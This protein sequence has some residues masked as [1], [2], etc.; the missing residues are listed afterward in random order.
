MIEAERDPVHRAAAEWFAR[1][2]G[3]ELSL[4]E[5]LAWQA[6]MN[7]NPQNAAAFARIEAV[8]TAL[9]MLPRPERP[10]PSAHIP[11]AWVASFLVATVACGWLAFKLE[12]LPGAP[13]ANVLQTAPGENRTVRLEDGSSVILGG[14]TRVDVAITPG[15]RAL[16]LQHGEALFKV[17]RDPSRPFEVRAGTATITALGTAFNVNRTQKRVVVSVIEGR[18]VVEP[19]S[20][21]V[22]VALL[23]ELK[24]G[25]TPVSLAAGEQTTADG[26]G[27][28]TAQRL[29]DPE[30][31]TAWQSGTLSFRLE[32]LGRALEDV[33]R[34]APKPIVAADERVSALRVT[35]TVSSSNVPGWIASLESA[36]G[37]RA[38]EQPDRIVLESEP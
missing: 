2:R 37:L 36:L 18:V 22:P 4:E 8:S 31:V 25:L 27:V 33:N 17:A 15:K 20:K 23:R 10:R 7:E 29:A 13:T 1:L 12:L 30:A 35:G 21:I 19:S 32:P 6:W 14:A 11:L 5:T 16:S 24:P 3:E 9:R 28:E 34:Y 38:I 26:S